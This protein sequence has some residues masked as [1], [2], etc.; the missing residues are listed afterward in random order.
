MSLVEDLLK[1]D[2]RA[3]AKLISLIEDGDPAAVQAIGEIYPR[4]GG[5]HVIG[6]SGPP[7]SGKSTLIF[8]LAQEFRS[9]GKKVGIIAV[10]PTS[11][12]TG[13]ALLGDRIRMGDLTKD[14]GAFIRSMATRGRLG[15]V[16]AATS[17][18]VNVLD[19][20]GSQV[21]FVETAGAG[22]TDVEVSDLVHTTVIVLMP[23]VGDEVQALKAGLFEVADIFVVNKADIDDA[24]RVVADLR[25]MLELVEEGGEWTPPVLKAVALH[26]EGVSELADYLERHLAFLHES[27]RLKAW[28]RRR[29][30]KELMIAVSETL[31]ERARGMASLRS[32]GDYVDKVLEKELSPKEAAV[33]L[34]KDSS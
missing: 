32:F 21:I 1:G 4:T 13:G 5:A 16:S 2:K 3:V 7:G 29:V 11:P 24:D 27:D 31:L 22:Q 30:E 8:R 33:G 10:D 17:D 26:G 12:I 28:N 9:R 23:G 34:L 14:E 6:V 25:M 20:Y 15:G 19:A 18:V